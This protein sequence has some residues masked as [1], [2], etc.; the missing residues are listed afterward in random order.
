MPAA[1]IEYPSIIVNAKNNGGWHPKGRRAYRNAVRVIYDCLQTYFE[2]RLF[3]LCFEGKT[4][5]VHK[6]LLSELVQ[7]VDRAGIRCEWFAA[8]ET[9]DVKGEHLHVMM[10]IDAYGLK[11]LKIFNRCED[12][13]L[14]KLCAKHGVK[15]GL[16]KP[17]DAG[18]HGLNRYIA[19]PYL[20]VGNKATERAHK[21]LADALIWATYLFKARSKPLGADEKNGQL[22]PASRPNRK[23]A[24]PLPPPTRIKR[25]PKS[26]SASGKVANESTY[27][28]SA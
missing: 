5:R 15:L 4:N 10:I 3:H 26:R 7:M 13:P 12:Q 20:G 6:K 22:F 25:V 1:T 18:L 23:R 27:L 14:A 11:A 2:P 21:R 16:F 28:L 24:V 17:R 9:D 19:L 8:R